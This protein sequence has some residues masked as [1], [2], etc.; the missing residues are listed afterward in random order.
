MD[1][2]CRCNVRIEPWRRLL[3]TQATD[4]TVSYRYRW[5]CNSHFN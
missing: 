4:K 3:S 2:L 5:K 1:I